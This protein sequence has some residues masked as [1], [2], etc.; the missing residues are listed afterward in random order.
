MRHFLNV[1]DP[2]TLLVPSAELGRCASVIEEWKQ[3]VRHDNTELWDCRRVLDAAVHPTLHTEIPVWGRMAAFIPVNVPICF[4]M[5]NAHSQ[6]AML[7]WQWF[8]Q[9]FNTCVTTG[10]GVG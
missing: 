5:L 6:G 4:G 7:F 8:N 9:S 3:G 1:L 10:G 2:R